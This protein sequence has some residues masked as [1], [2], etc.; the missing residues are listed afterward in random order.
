MAPGGD[1]QLSPR[2]ANAAVNR[3][4]VVI[5]MF[6][7]ERN[8]EGVVDDL[9]AQDYQGDVEVFV[10]NGGSTDRSRKLL[11]AAAERT[12][13]NVTVIENPRRVV[14]HGLNA[15]I[16]RATGDLIVRVDCRSRYPHDYLRRLAARA[17]ET[18]AWNVAPLLEAIGGT[19]MERA[20]ACAMD[21]P[22]GGIAW[23]RH[24]RAR[25]PVEVDTVYIGAYRPIAFER[26]G[27]FDASMGDN[28]DEDFNLRVRKAGGRIVLDPTLRVRYTPAGSFR[29]VFDR[30]YAY[31]IYKP[32]VM[33]KHR[34]V[35][36]ARSLVPP[37]FVGSLTALLAASA[38][39]PGARRL[40][41]AEIGLYAAG[42]LA[43]GA[44]SI[45]RR[46]ESWRLL[47]R[48]V[49]VFPTFHVAY[50][51]GMVAGWLRQGRLARGRAAS[52][53]D[54]ASP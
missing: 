22:F 43:F 41:A 2:T 6:N 24:E 10:A 35:L 11:L 52:A 14:P 3:I 26:A 29:G 20:V 53:P 15:C 28:H 37:V 33:R 18:G 8:V 49:A 40:L 34:Q 9:A 7:E 21:S 19:S 31:G 17:E 47:P 36:S 4:S 45:V 25:E 50:G 51:L 42:A 16:A 44:A 39:F 27:L 54:T 23:T 13:L 5:P 1:E 30:Y 48:V 32:P 12:G 38:P 46:R